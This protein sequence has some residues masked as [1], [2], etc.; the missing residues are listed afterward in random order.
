MQEQFGSATGTVEHW[1]RQSS[2]SVLHA[3]DGDAGDVAPMSSASE[4]LAYSLP[5]VESAHVDGHLPPDV[6]AEWSGRHLSDSVSV[7]AKATVVSGQP[8]EHHAN[9]YPEPLPPSWIIKSPKSL[10]RRSDVREYPIDKEALLFDPC[11][12]MLY[13]LNETAFAIWQAC[14]GRTMREIARLL[15]GEYDSEFDVVLG[16]AS[17]I[18]NVLALGGLFDHE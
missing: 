3:H 12:Q 9:Q 14:D 7:H 18:V 10:R 8:K 13:Y 11:T 1:A 5:K 17:Q 4:K 16:H 2:S 6:V 15:I